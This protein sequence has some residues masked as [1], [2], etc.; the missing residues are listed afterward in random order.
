MYQFA[1]YHRKIP[2]VPEDHLMLCAIVGRRPATPTEDFVCLE[3][4]FEAPRLIVGDGKRSN[5][6]N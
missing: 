1:W 3:K 5:T 4:R 2:R 6:W